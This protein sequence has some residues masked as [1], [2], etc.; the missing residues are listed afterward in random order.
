[1][2]SVGDANAILDGEVDSDETLAKFLRVEEKILDAS[3]AIHSQP[4]RVN[5][6]FCMST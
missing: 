2:A 1:V 5:P 4:F 3:Q 6:M